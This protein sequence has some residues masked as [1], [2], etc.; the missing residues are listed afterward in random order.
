MCSD[1][2]LPPQPSV[3]PAHVPSS[4]SS[5]TGICRNVVQSSHTLRFILTFSHGATGTAAKPRSAM[6]EMKTALMKGGAVN[7]DSTEALQ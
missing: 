6:A 2:F 1:S 5:E 3:P 4:N 7:R